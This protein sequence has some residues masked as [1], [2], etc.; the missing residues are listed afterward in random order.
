VIH[1]TQPVLD[2]RQLKL[3]FFSEKGVVQAVDGID[4]TIR[5]GEIVGLVGESGCGKSVTSLSIMGLVPQPPGK[6]VNGSIWFEG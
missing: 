1:L 5:R 2:I 4:L 3:H 6:I